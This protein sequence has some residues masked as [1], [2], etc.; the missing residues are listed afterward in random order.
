MNKI[1]RYVFVFDQYDGDKF[2]YDSKLGCRIDNLRECAGI[3]NGKEDKIEELKKQVQ[4]KG[5][6]YKSLLAMATQLNDVYDTEGCEYGD[7]IC[8]NTPEETANAYIEQ[9]KIQIQRENE[10]C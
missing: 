3:L 8:G 10:K 9:T 1:D 5:L 4:E 7:E 2:I 6:L